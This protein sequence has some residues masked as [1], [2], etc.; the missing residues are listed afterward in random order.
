MET[1]SNGDGESD[2]GCAT[3]VLQGEGHTLA[4][5]LKHQ[6]N[7]SL[8]VQLAGYSVPHYSDNAV[9]I[10]VQ[11]TGEVSAKD[12]IMCALL[13]GFFWGTFALDSTN[14]EENSPIGYFSLVEAAPDECID[15]WW[16]MCNCRQS[17]DELI[18]MCDHVEH[19]F[20][21]R[22]SEFDD[23]MHGQAST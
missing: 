17:I 20:T 8:H 5:P 14:D 19:E 22:L 16:M 3:F 21:Q 11:T 23:A 1:E 7:K 15:V 10:R 2:T 12:A 9:H 4:N 13:W 18:E 6:L